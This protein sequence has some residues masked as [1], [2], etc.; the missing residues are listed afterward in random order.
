[1]N[2]VERLKE[3]KDMLEQGFITQDEFA[4][5]RAEVMERMGPTPFVSVPKAP[6]RDR[7]MFREPT[8]GATVAVT[9]G[10]TILWTLLFGCF[11]L[12]YKELWLHA[13]L[14]LVAA[15]FTYGISWLIYPFFV[16]R[17]VV[18]SYRRRGWVEI[19]PDTPVSNTGDFSDRLVA[20][21]KVF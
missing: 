16:Y 18:D 20:R 7:V 10:G 2:R 1:M 17:L 14:S 11:Y 9:R 12:A 8:T 19:E 6:Q 13:V 4:K 5:L 21:F 3:L 15:I